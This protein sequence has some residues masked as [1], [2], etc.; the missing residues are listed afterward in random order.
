M[1]TYDEF[2][3]SHNKLEK[4]GDLLTGVDERVD[5]LARFVTEKTGL[6]MERLAVLES[7]VLEPAVLNMENSKTIRLSST[8]PASTGIRLT[9]PALGRRATIQSVITHF[10]DG[11][12]ALVDIAFGSGTYQLVPL[13]GFLA[14]NDASPSFI[15][16]KVIENNEDLWAIINNFDAGFA[17]TISI[18]VTI[19]EV[20]DG[21]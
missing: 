16:N 18:I 17:H 20:T 19:S 7:A 21:S 12:D 8:V 6:I 2:K 5:W 15:I 13:E 1:E 10:P 14:L 4:V 11:C 3:Q 9:S